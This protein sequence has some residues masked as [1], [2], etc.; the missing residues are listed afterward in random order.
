MLRDPAKDPKPLAQEL[1]KILIGPVKADLDQAQAETLVWSLDGV[2]RYVPM[3]ALYDG[4]QYLV[5]NYN[6]VTITPASIAHLAEKPDVSNLSAAAMGISREYE[7]GLSRASGGGGR[8]GRR[9]E[10]C[11]GAGRT[12]RVAGIDP[13]EQSIHREGDG[14]PARAASTRWCISPATSYS[15]RG[16]TASPICCWR[17][18]KK[19]A[20]GFHL[21]V[22]D[23]RDNKN[24]VLASYRPADAFGLRNGDERQCQQRPRGGWAWDDG[25]T[26]RGQG[27]DLVAVGGERR[28]H[29]RVDGRLLQ[30]LGRRRRAR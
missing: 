18:R 15:S 23:F 6:T 17:A 25:A 1:Y 27:G 21:T 10:G 19:A 13:A 20:Q 11:A 2:L 22:A 9:G 8:V 7:D 3:A 28:Q 26:E 30:A 14:E 12:W 29:R 16:T 24:L 5:E 4:K